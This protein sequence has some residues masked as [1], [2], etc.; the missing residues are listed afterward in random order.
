MASF[1][2]KLSNV[3]SQSLLNCPDGKPLTWGNSDFMHRHRGVDFFR[4][5]STNQAMDGVKMLVLGGEE[6]FATHYESALHDLNSTGKNFTYSSLPMLSYENLRLDDCISK[7]D[8]TSPRVVWIALGSPKQELV[9]SEL[10]RL[11]PQIL[12]VTIGAAIDF[13]SE[14]KEEAPVW[15]QKIGFEWLFRFLQEPHRLGKR[16]FFGN[17]A[18]LFLL[19]AQHLAKKS[20]PKNFMEIND[21]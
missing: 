5:I 18:F 9:A 11:Y 17:S 21:N 7:I 19:I 16:Y 20:S 3:L 6:R 2:G 10:S 13:I 15:L 8:S 4:A 14:V 1:S 12:F